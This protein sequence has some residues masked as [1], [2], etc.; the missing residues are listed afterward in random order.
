MNRQ[1]LVKAIA[2]ES[3]HSQSTVGEVLNSLIST[4]QNVVASGDKISLV[5][6]GTF[7]ST[8]QAE[9]QGRNPST[10]API[11]IAASIKPKFTPGKSFKDRVNQ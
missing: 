6:F 1:E 5:G 8:K 9:R 3:G 10:G 7:E 2:D 11:T 4:V